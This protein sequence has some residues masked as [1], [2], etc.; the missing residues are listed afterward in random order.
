MLID[1]PRKRVA[2]SEKKQFV[3]MDIEAEQ[4]LKV[5][6]EYKVKHLVEGTRDY[7]HK[8]DRIL[9]VQCIKLRHLYHLQSLLS[10]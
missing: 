1:I 4:L 6:H 9:T 7:R 2:A 3:W 8:I 10:S 5:T